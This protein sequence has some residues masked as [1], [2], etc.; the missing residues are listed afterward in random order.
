MKRC[1][2]LQFFTSSLNTRQIGIPDSPFNFIDENHFSYLT[3]KSKLNYLDAFIEA[4]EIARAHLQSIATILNDGDDL[5]KSINIICSNK[6]NIEILKE[7]LIAEMLEKIKLDNGYDITNEFL[8]EKFKQ[9]KKEHWFLLC[10]FH[11][12]KLEVAFKHLKPDK[13]EY[14]KLKV[15]PTIENITT[16]ESYKILANYLD[17]TTQ[18]T[19]SKTCKFF[20]QALKQFKTNLQAQYEIM[21][22]YSSRF[23]RLFALV[24]DRKNTEL[25]QHIDSFEFKDFK[26]FFQKKNIDDL[27]LI[28]Y[29]HSKNNLDAIDIIYQKAKSCFESNGHSHIKFAIHCHQFDDVLAET[30]RCSDD[31]ILD[32]FFDIDTLAYTVD[33]LEVLIAE[34]QIEIFQ[35]LE[36]IV[37]LD[38]KKIFNAPNTKGLNALELAALHNQTTLVKFLL[39]YSMEFLTDNNCNYRVFCYCAIHKNKDMFVLLLNELTI[40]EQRKTF[41]LD[42]FD[43]NIEAVHKLPIAVRSVL[44]SFKKETFNYV[45]PLALAAAM[46]HEQIVESLYPQYIPLPELRNYQLTLNLAL[47]YA[48]FCKQ[49]TLATKLLTEYKETTLIE[50]DVQDIADNEDEELEESLTDVAFYEAAITGNNIQIFQELF[51]LTAEKKAEIFNYAMEHQNLDVVSQ[52]YPIFDSNFSVTEAR[53]LFQLFFENYKLHLLVSLIHTAILKRHHCSLQVLLDIFSEFLSHIAKPKMD[54]ALKKICLSIF[55]FAALFA[56]EEALTVIFKKIPS[57]IFMPCSIKM[58]KDFLLEDLSDLIQILG[59]KIV[60]HND[61]S[62]FKI[63]YA[64]DNQKLLLQ[65]ITFLNLYDTQVVTQLRTE[66]IDLLHLDKNLTGGRIEFFRACFW[67]LPYFFQLELLP[68]ISDYTLLHTLL[69]DAV[70]TNNFN[71]VSQLIKNS[72]VDYWSCYELANELEHTDI[73]KLFEQTKETHIKMSYSK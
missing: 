69:K 60:N 36:N 4:Y 65:Q 26:Y 34:G 61:I 27:D 71:L 59:K 9:L 19:L 6:S 7:Q 33:L 50:I 53:P 2:S 46:G 23:Q 43:N 16:Q 22:N 17:K 1:F 68:H 47:I 67:H 11:Y 20:S 13:P 44:Y 30:N 32:D 56:T 24:R 38:V 21:G 48:L 37:H 10:S 54:E 15:T 72:A 55:S 70:Q 57:D 58:I 3:L 31:G 49:N 25:K 63:L 66:L 14:K 5:S 45:M 73:A 62:L 35:R 12:Q 18:S 40:P 41:L 39:P 29:A 8:T 52:L 42:I 51:T 28:A 64:R